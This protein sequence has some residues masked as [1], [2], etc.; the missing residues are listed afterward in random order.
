MP[1]LTGTLTLDEMAAETTEARTIRLEQMGEERVA[2]AIQ[3]ELD[4]HGATLA[5]QMREF[6]EITTDN[7]RRDAAHGTSGE[8]VPLTETG[9]APTQIVERG[10]VT[11]G[12]PLEGWQFAIGWTQRALDRASANRL[13]LQVNEAR[14]AHI[15]RLQAQLKVALYAPTNKTIRD[16]LTE[17]KIDL[18]VKRFYNGDGW[19]IP[20][21]PNGE[22]F[23]GATHTHYLAGAALTAPLAMAMIDT[24]REHNPGV[25]VRV[26]INQGNEAEWSALTGF[27]AFQEQGV[28]RAAGQLT[29]P[30]IDLRNQANRAIGRFHG[31]EVWVK[32]WALDDYAVAYAMS[33][34]KPLVLR[35]PENRGGVPALRLAATNKAYPLLAEFMESEFG[36]G[37]GNRAGAAILYPGG[38]SYAVPTIPNATFA[39]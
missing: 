3:R 8:M 14:A 2:A 10:P 18:A 6:A 37:A 36:F 19:D 20:L 23:D 11:V 35:V 13:A 32:P 39:P 16:Y 12:F 21:G 30:D 9:R 26:V 33:G 22:V 38:A 15:R 28:V 1:L 17:N 31:A 25:D 29:G 4:I 27:K 24:V 7:Q 34:P 5:E